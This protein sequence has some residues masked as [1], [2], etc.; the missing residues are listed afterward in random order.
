MTLESL[1]L[2]SFRAHKH[3][4]VD[5]TPKVNVLVGSNG[6]GKTNTLEA[7][8][9]LCLTKSFVA[10]NDTYAVRQEAPYF[11]LEGTFTGVRSRPMTVKLVYVPHEGKQVFVNDAPLERLADIVGQLPVVVFSPEDH[12]LTAEGPDERRRF[13]NNILSQA[14]PAYMNTLMKY[15]RARKQRNELLRQYRKKS[16]PPPEPLLAPWTQK[17]V[18]LG[19]RVVARRKT[20]LGTFTTYLQDAYQRIQTVAEKPTI[21]YD[22]FPTGS[23]DLP[24]KSSSIAEAFRDRLQEKR[25]H[26]YK[27]GT[28]LVGPQRDELIFRLD[29]LEV[30]RYASQGQHRTFAMALKLAQYFY[31]TDTLDRKPLL[32]LDDAFGKLD[33]ARTEVF[34]ELLQSDDIGQS[35]ITSTRAAPFEASVPFHEPI[36]QLLRVDTNDGAARVRSDASSENLSETA[37]SVSSS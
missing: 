31:L 10:S 23:T 17:V 15:N 20:F 16:S 37:A 21:E 19:S 27:R 11:E 22:S 2:R 9:Y 5:F 7:I 18:Q 29:G 6:V 34:M 25:D 13:L 33:T 36:H 1:R 24:D 30:R 12:A 28:T 8:H 26:E 35:F 14:H 32:L 4:E 3:T